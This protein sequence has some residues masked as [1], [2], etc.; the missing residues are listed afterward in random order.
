[1]NGTK[2]FVLCL[3]LCFV[4]F[5]PLAC[6]ADPGGNLIIDKDTGDHDIWLGAIKVSGYYRLSIYENRTRLGGWWKIR[7]VFG[8]V[9]AEDKEHVIFDEIGIPPKEF[10][11]SVGLAKG[12]RLEQDIVRKEH[13]CSFK[14]V[15]K[16]G[17]ITIN[18]IDASFDY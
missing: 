3:V 17:G 7:D 15:V 8:D 2:L 16:G 11:S 18:L 10:H 12:V 6:N 5:G 1:M 14:I 13:S 9:L 4:F